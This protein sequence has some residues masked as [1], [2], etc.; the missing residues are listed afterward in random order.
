[1][2][3]NCPYCSNKKVKSNK[4]NSLF[5]LFPEIA[6]EW[7]YEKNGDLKPTDVTKG[8]DKKVWWKCEKGHSWQSSPNIIRKNR[9]K[10]KCPYCRN[11]KLC[12]ENSLEAVNK[13]LSKEWN[14]DK[15]I[16]LTPKEVLFNSTRKVWWKCKKGHSWETSVYNRTKGTNCPICWQERRSKGRQ[17]SIR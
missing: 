7:D 11:K 6:K 8:S 10:E 2:N 15:N 17:I 16:N 14:Y 5:F 13:K 9:Q 4:E 12:K 1:M 3:S